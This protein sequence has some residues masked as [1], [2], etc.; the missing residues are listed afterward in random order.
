[1]ATCEALDMFGVLERGMCVDQGVLRYFAVACPRREV[2]GLVKRA[3]VRH[4]RAPAQQDP[5][6]VLNRRRMLSGDGL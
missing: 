1:M 3:T 5:Q 4:A 2:G 6:A